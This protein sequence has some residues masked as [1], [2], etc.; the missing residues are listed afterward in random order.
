MGGWKKER[1]REIDCEK[2]TNDLNARQ[3][4][5]QQQAGKEEM[6][7]KHTQ[8][9][10]GEKRRKRRRRRWG[11]D[12]GLQAGACVSSWVGWV[13]GWVGCSLISLVHFTQWERE[14]SPPPRM[15]KGTKEYIQMRRST[16]LLFPFP[17]FSFS[18]LLPPRFVLPSTTTPTL[19]TPS[20]P[21]NATD[22][23]TRPPPLPPPPTGR[24]TGK[25]SRAPRGKRT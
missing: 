8:H 18:H 21:A 7:I 22:D 3:R 25:D 23:A 14:G 12:S 19:T 15:P 13:G 17:F 24:Y 10:K 9:T 2:E 6:D 1:E 20:T 4:Q 5:K 16:R 11:I